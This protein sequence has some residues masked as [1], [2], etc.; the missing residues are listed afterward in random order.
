M[1]NRVRQK[2][3]QWFR[4]AKWGVFCHYLAS[5]E[6]DVAEWNS[7]VDSFD[8]ERLACQLE[9]AGVKYFIITIGQNSG[10]YCS[11]NQTYDSIVGI[12]PSKCSNRDLVSDL[13]DALEPKGIKLMVY[14]TLNAPYYDPVAQEKLEWEEKEPIGRDGKRFEDFQLKWDAIVRE[15]SLRWGEKVKGWWIDGCYFPKSNYEQPNGPDFASF[16]A[17]MRAGNPNS[18]VAFNPGVNYPIISMTE[19][20]DYTA[21][22]AAHCLPLGYWDN[23]SNYYP[24]S[25]SVEGAQLHTL[26]FLGEYWGLGSPRFSKELTVG[27]TQY[28]CEHGGV[29]SWDVPISPDGQIPQSYIDTLSQI[30]KGN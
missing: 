20:E 15:W 11:P 23:N 6:M 16:A 26:I 4:E 21:G 14:F 28:F 17:A 5:N 27:F 3:V 18:I 25:D 10:H 13:F 1:E 29:V 12:Y 22:E 2:R 19:E 8:T 9:F 30:D 7:R 24:V